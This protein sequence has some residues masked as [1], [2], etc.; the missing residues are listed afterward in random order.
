MEMSLEIGR[1][2]R[3]ISVNGMMMKIGTFKKLATDR[4]QVAVASSGRYG[5]LQASKHSPAVSSK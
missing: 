1:I 5:F 4:L 2:A 3:L